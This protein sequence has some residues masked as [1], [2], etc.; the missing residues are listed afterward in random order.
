MPNSQR[1]GT[2]E[3]GDVGIPAQGCS[4]EPGKWRHYPTSRGRGPGQEDGPW[5]PGMAGSGCWPATR[6]LLEPDHL[7]SN[8]R[9]NT[10]QAVRSWPSHFTSASL[11]FPICRVE[12]QAIP[13]PKVVM[14]RAIPLDAR[15]SPRDTRS[16]G[17]GRGTHLC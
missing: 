5:G 1:W 12:I 15:L 16:P 17:R 8:P 3:D 11:N 13:T 9:P 4:E 6:Q 14:R 2:A 10:S 7:G